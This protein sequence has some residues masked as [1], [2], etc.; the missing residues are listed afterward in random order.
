MRLAPEL[1]LGWS[2]GEKP[3]SLKEFKW[4][5]TKTDYLE[6]KFGEVQREVGMEVE[7]VAQCIVGMDDKTCLRSPLLQECTTKI[8]S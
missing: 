1:K 6:C 4:S 2:F 3:W 8:K 7:H 5:R